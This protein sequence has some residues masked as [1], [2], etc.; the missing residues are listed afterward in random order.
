MESQTHKPKLKVAQV[1]VA[2]F[3]A[4]RRARMRDTGLFDLVAVHDWNREAQ[5]KAA[6]EEGAAQAG[7]YNELLDTPGIEAMVISTGAMFHAE[8]AIAAMERGLHVFVEKPLCSTPEEAREMLAAQRLNGVVAAS[9]HVD[10]SYDPMAQI[11]ARLIESGELG[12]IAAVE[13]TSA[14]SGGHHIK[15]GDWRGDPDKNP[16]GMLFHCSIHTIYELMYHFGP[17]DRV[18]CITREDLHTTGTADTTHCHLVFRS[19]LT[20][21][22]N[23]YHVTP[24]FNNFNIFG[25]EGNLYRD[26]FPTGT[27]LAKQARHPQRMFEERVTLPLPPHQ[28]HTGNLLSFYDAIRRGQGAHPSWQQAAD[29]VE[30]VFAAAEAARTGST[31]TVAP[32]RSMALSN[33]NGHGNGHPAGASA[34]ACLETV[35]NGYNV[36]ASSL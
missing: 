5:E 21:A 36:L 27:I 13:S 3:G 7:T 1:G 26:H 35:T 20:A 31:V 14:H 10:L 25:T 12:T 16:G 4:H 9:G 22:L 23:A 19:G 28:E 33:G 18:S 17:V 24:Y 6:A 8:Q 2:R 11:T 29:A 34:K 30:V 15:P 32:T